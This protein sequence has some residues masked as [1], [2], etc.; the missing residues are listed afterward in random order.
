MASE[1]RLEWTLDGKP[2]IPQWKAKAGP[3]LVQVV[4]LSS[5]EFVWTVVGVDEDVD[6]DESYETLLSAQLAAE[7]AALSWLREGVAALGG[8]VLEAGEVALARHAFH[9]WKTA[10]CNFQPQT[11]AEL[12][13]LA[14]ARKLGGG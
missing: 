6:S 9:C 8:V 14:L 13:M 11:T 3:L 2:N 5:G 1:L 7:A 12:R 4:E 10:Y